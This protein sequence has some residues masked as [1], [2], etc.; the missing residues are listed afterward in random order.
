MI[1]ELFAGPN[2][3]LSS[4]RVFLFCWLCY[5]HWVPDGKVPAWLSVAIGLL[6]WAGGQHVAAMFGRVGGDMVKQATEALRARI[7]ARRKIGAE[8]GTEPTE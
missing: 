7:A 2:D 6:S 4:A 5:F 1:R 8:D 3:R